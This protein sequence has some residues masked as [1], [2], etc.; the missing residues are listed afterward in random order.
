MT[1]VGLHRANE[2]NKAVILGASGFIGVNLARALAARGFALFCFARHTSEL[3]PA[4]S[5]IILGD[6]AHPPRQLL[7][8]MEGSIVFHLAN[9]SRPTES[10]DKAAAEIEA[11]LIATVGLLEATKGLDCRWVFSSSGG[12]VYGQSDAV[13]ITEEHSTIPISSYGTVKLATER[14]FNLFKT[15]HGVDSVIARIS[16]PFGPY[17]SAAKGQGLVAALFDR[18]ASGSPVEVWGDG[19]NVRDYVYIDDVTRALIL[20][21]LRGSA[22]E[23]YNVGSG[24]GTS[25]T[26]LVTKISAF[27]GVPAE[28]V[29]THARGID[30]HRNVLDIRKI[31]REL[32]WRPVYTLEEGIRLTYHWRQRQS[33]LRDSYEG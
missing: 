24:V 25:V 13:Q 11:D 16:N 5:N 4:E 6:L 3:W 29:Y 23:I 12:T 8:A 20:L 7:A 32:G 19:K 1:Q 18:I 26:E 33:Q 2:R 9:S 15:L 22:G 17:Q 30:V 10:T 31:G 28:L 14:Y 21:G 27:L